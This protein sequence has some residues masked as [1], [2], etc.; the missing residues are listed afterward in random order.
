MCGFLI[1]G[2]YGMDKDVMFFRVFNK[3]KKFVFI[4]LFC[5]MIV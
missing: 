2:G 5:F 3:Y 4:R 1:I